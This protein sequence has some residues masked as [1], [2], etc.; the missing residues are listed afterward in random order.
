MI[1]GENAVTDIV[2]LCKDS[3]GGT[4][5]TMNIITGNVDRR[6]ANGSFTATPIPAWVATKRTADPKSLWW[7]CMKL[8]YNFKM[9]Y[10]DLVSSSDDNDMF[11]T[12]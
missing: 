2:N 12:C 4:L 1:R 8:R 7:L 5:T 11:I 10:D 6:S 9:E 3:N